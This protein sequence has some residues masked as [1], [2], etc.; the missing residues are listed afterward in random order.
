MVKRGG[1]L[2]VPQNTLHHH[3]ESFTTYLAVSVFVDIVTQVY[4]V[5]N[6]ILS[7]NISIR[8][9]ETLWVVTAGVYSN[10]DV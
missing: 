9:E 6:T 2:N 4:N 10:L 7:N 1:L 5:V 3:K 8:V